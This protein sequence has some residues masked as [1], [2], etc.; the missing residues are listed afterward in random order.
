MVDSFRMNNDQ[1]QKFEYWLQLFQE[2]KNEIHQQKAAAYHAALVDY[3]KSLK[4]SH[5]QLKSETAQLLR[6]L[7]KHGVLAEKRS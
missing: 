5:Q 4:I 3:A 6:S 2:S 7:R 1:N